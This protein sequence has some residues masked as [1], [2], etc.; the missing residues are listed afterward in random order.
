[1]VIKI[2]TAV[3]EYAIYN[4]LH[5]QEFWNQQIIFG[6]NSFSFEMNLE[7]LFFYTDYG[8]N[9]IN[10]EFSLNEENSL[11]KS[12]VTDSIEDITKRV[13]INYIDLYVD[14]MFLTNNYCRGREYEVRNI[15]VKEDKLYSSLKNSPDLYFYYY[16]LSQFSFLI[17]ISK[18]NFGECTY[19]IHNE[20]DLKIFKLIKNK[21]NI[22]LEYQALS[23]HPISFICKLYELKCKS[24]EIDLSCFSIDMCI[25]IMNDIKLKSQ[26]K[27][28]NN[29]IICF[30]K[31][32]FSTSNRSIC[33]DTN[34]KQLMEQSF[35]LF[36]KVILEY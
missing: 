20:E 13:T 14:L 22:S 4:Y 10:I 36:S 8:I 6:S 3:V 12:D 30:K 7:N 1:M 26:V 29:K 28:N 2:I 32:Y 33:I 5:S 16:D 17:D 21:D 19:V 23:D 31:D 15:Y 34:S 18:Y 25:Q 24:I 35:K 9:S 11:S 27:I